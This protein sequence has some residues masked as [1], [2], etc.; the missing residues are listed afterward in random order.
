MRA[1]AVWQF[2]NFI[3]ERSPTGS[4]PPIQ[5]TLDWVRQLVLL[6]EERDLRQV[7]AS[8]LHMNAVRLM[9]VHGSKGLE[10]EA[11]HIPGL[12]VSSFP[13]SNRGQR[14]PAPDGMMMGAENLTGAEEAKRAHSHEEECLFF[15]AASRARTHLR[16][17]L[18]RHQ[19]NPHA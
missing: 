17:Y 13:S 18:A 5:R 12:T 10:F 16:L 6:A 8:V 14:C 19:P 11:V 2:L 1:V 9:T 7:P 4:G 3:R 15:V